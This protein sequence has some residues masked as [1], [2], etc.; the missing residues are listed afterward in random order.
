MIFKTYKDI[1][2]LISI[3][4][5]KMTEEQIVKSESEKVHDEHEVADVPEKKTRELNKM[6]LKAKLHFKIAS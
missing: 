4:I 2:L 1:I 5:F 3:I 6:T